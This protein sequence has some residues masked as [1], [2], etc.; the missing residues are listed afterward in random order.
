MAGG[1]WK[2]QNKVRPGAYINVKSKDIAM[3]RLGGDGVVTVPLALSFGESK[4]LMKIRRGEDLF[5]K[6]GYEQESPQLLLLNEAFKRVSEVLLYRLNTGEKANVSLSDNVTAQAKYS[7][8]R[9]NDITVTVKTNVDD[10]S[11]FDV[12]TFL[13][14]VVMDSQTVKVLADLKNNDLVEFS[15]TGELQAVAG[16]KLTGGTDGTVSTQDYS[17]Y[18]KA[19]ETV[20]FNYMALP[21]EDA[22]I[23]KAAINFIKRMREDEGLGAQLVVADSDADSE[24]VINVKNGVILSDKTVIDKTKATVYEKYEDSVDVVGRLSHTE[25]EDALLKGQFVFTARRGRAVVE[26]DIN[27]HVSFTI[28]KNQDFRKNRIL[29]TL[30]DIVNDTRYAFSEYFLGKVSNNEDGRQAF[31]ANRIRYFKDLEA[32]GAIED[33]KVEDIEVLRG[34]LKESVVVNVKVKPVDSM[35]KLYMTVTVE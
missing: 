2:R 20:E 1:I 24:A 5:K 13:D 32:R 26:Q 19:L 29:R 25:T 17:E 15:G 35:E 9:G 23:K 6:L 3:T 33:F 18:F 21:V 34:E 30:D 31:K 4:K 10:P 8:V 28:E 14:T 11:S 16:A 7:G 27:S 12:V 22:S